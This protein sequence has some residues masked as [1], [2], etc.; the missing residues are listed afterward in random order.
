MPI[1]MLPQDK[2]GQELFNAISTFFST[3]RIGNLLHKCNAQNFLLLDLMMIGLL[4]I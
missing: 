1:S 2:D 4:L 3:F